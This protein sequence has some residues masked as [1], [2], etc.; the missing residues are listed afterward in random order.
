MDI[1]SEQLVRKERGLSYV[2][3]KIGIL[4]GAFI[5]SLL[6]IGVILMFF[7]LLAMIGFLGGFGILYLGIYLSNTLDIEYEYIVT[8][9]CLDID[10]I[11]AMKSRKR[12]V[13]VDIPT[14]EQ[15]GQYTEDTEIPDCNATIEAIYSRSAPLYYAVFDDERYGKTLLLFNPD[16]KT[17]DTVDTSLPRQLRVF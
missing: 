6:F 10:K 13:S 2:L 17:L 7:R 14:F 12:L 11:I 5:L 3:K 9:T 16:D 1:Y 4:V 15:F 8:G